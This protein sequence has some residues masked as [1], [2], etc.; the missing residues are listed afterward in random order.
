MHMRVGLDMCV[1]VRGSRVCAIEHGHEGSRLIG[2]WLP[3][4]PAAPPI[5]PVASFNFR[6]ARPLENHFLCV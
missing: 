3:L 6:F 2:Y 1:F 5:A 4:D